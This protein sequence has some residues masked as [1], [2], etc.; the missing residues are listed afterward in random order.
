MAAT[1]R[2]TY[3]AT[4]DRITE[5]GPETRSFTLRLPA[6][7][8]FTF[9]PGQFVSCLLPVD[10]E[11]LIRPYSLASNPEELPGLDIC[12][13]RVCGGRGSGYLFGLSPGVTL[14][15]TGPWGTFRLDRQPDSETVFIAQGPGIVPIRPMLRRALRN[16]AHPLRLYYAAPTPAHLLYGPELAAA[17]HAESRFTYTPIVA[18]P[19]EAAVEATFIAADAIRTRAFF[20]CAVGDIVTRLRD[21]LRAA[22]YERRAVQYEKW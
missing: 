15:F 11:T 8:A 10:G 20:I 22:G 14:Q 19:L 2:V 12:L 9:T 18:G 1:E 4:I 16:G 13:N 17:A 7:S 5:I 21:R 3:A 6:A